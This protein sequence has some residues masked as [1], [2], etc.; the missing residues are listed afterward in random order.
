NWSDGLG[1]RYYS[2]T[3]VAG[4]GGTRLF[5][6]LTNVG[7]V[8]IDDV[9]LVQGT[10]AE[11]G[12]NILQNGDFET[13]D[14]TGW[15]VSGNHLGSVVTSEVAHQG[16]YSIH[17]IST[18]IGT[19]V[20]ALSQLNLVGV[21]TTSPYTLSFYYLPSSV[22]GLQYRLTSFFRN[23]E[24]LN[25]SPILFTPGAANTS[26][27]T[28]PP[29]DEVWLNEVQSDNGSGIMDNQGERDPWVELFNNGAAT[30][31]LEGYYLANNYDSNLTQWAFP[32]G[33]TID[34]GEFKI[35][36]LDGQPGQSSGDH[37]HASFRLAG[38]AG[39]L[40]LVRLVEG[41]PQITDYL[42]YDGLAA[43]ESYGDFPDGEPF[44]RAVFNTVTPGAANIARPADLFINEWMA[45]NQATL[46]DPADGNYEDWFELYN[47]GTEPVDL[48]GF[49]LTDNL[50]NKTQFPIPSGYVIDPGGYMLVW[51]DNDVEQND[52]NSA[53]L[54][55]NFALSQGGEAIGLFS[56]AGIVVDQ[57][58]FS[59]QTNDISQGRFPD[60]TVSLQWFSLPTPG[61][62]NTL[63]GDNTAP[64]IDPIDDLTVVAGQT[65][66]F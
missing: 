9:Y 5:M 39:S 50:N 32:A 41:A 33:T 58:L 11:A 23:L 6:W 66:D 24:P 26:D 4:S 16:N 13:G 51:A 63:G 44:K 30:I 19:A 14:L 8:F 28:L 61:A 34:P 2:F 52:P 48:T 22:A 31:S 25:V 43:D 60:G 12:P 38:P 15:N 47:A 37:L 62:A 36:W 27:G 21:D 7:D 59:R 54:H 65:V 18:G 17:V 10:V 49:Y 42:N 40:A 57:V 55:V 20:S 64:V 53:D 29:Y 35:I 46:V 45:S 3:A 1:W 56:P